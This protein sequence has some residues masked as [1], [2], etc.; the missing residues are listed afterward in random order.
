MVQ[1]YFLSVLF[2]LLTGLILSAEFL[3]DKIKALK[4][5]NEFFKTKQSSLTVISIISMI[6]GL[7]KI[8]SCFKGDLPVIGDLLPAFGGLIGGFTLFFMCYKEKAEVSTELTEKIDSI[9]LNNKA[10]IGICCIVISVLHFIFPAVIL[11]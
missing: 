2:N 3:S 5:F 11:L 1:I 6:I 8:L 9:M 10:L 7:F 4:S